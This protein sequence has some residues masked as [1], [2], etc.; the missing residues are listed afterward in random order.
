MQNLL[1]GWQTIIADGRYPVPYALTTRLSLVDLQDIAEAAAR[2]LLQPGHEGATYELVGTPG[3]TQL[4]VA[5]I[6]SQTLN[7]PVTA[8]A[9]PREQWRQ[10]A[11]AAGLNAYARETLL[12]MFEYYEQYGLWGSPIVLAWLLRRPPTSLA[13]F[14]QREMSR[15]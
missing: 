13:S 1:S 9:I 15:P 10:Q 5:A 2:V 11:I 6:L 4:E 3:L 7:R 12:Q 8:E 14:V